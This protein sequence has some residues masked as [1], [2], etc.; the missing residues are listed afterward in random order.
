MNNEEIKEILSE[1][2]KIIENT[3]YNEDFTYF[4]VSHISKL[5]DY[6]T[7]LEQVNKNQAKRNSR[8]RLA[9]TKQQELILKLQKENERLMQDLQECMDERNSLQQENEYLDNELN[10]MTDYAK[11]LEQENEY[12]KLNNPE[13][14]IEHFRIINENKRKIDNLRKQNEELM[15]NQRYYKNGIF[16]LEYDKE[17]LS[18]MVD[19]YKSRC[20]KAVEVIKQFD[21]DKNFTFPLMPKWEEKQVKASIKLEFKDTYKRPLL[22]I[23]QNGSDQNDPN[24]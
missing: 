20:E 19:D 13:M 12:L 22:N 21:T 23:L 7:N 2:N 24:K 8:Q 1:V 15:K 6:I 9:N 10:N 14:N 5:L 4:Q 3:A 18:D 11:D 17:T 16:S